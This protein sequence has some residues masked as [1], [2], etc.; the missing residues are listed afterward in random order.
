MTESLGRILERLPALASFLAGSSAIFA[1]VAVGLFAARRAPFVSWLGR[2]AER[3]LDGLVAAILLAMV[4]LSGL[5]ILLRN[6]FDAGFLWIDP[7]L[8]GAI[9]ATGMKR[10][11]QI[12][13]LGRLLRGGARRAAGAGVAVASAVGCLALARASLALLADELAFGDIVFLGIPAWLPAMVF[14]LS[15]ALL[16]FRFFH[17]ALREIAGEAPEAEERELAGAKRSG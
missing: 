7:L 12:N 5:Q 3:M 17:L 15:F 13:V 16:A 6:L 11:V 1:A 2:S 9:V 4:A 8:A 14:P 10:H